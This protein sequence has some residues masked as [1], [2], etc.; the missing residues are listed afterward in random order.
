MRLFTMTAI[1]SCLFA[2]MSLADVKFIERGDTKFSWIDLH[3]SGEI[4][5]DTVNRFKQLFQHFTDSD[6]HNIS[7]RVILTSRGGTVPAAMEIGHFL[8]E[9]EFNAVVPSNQVCLSSC[10]LIFV[11]AVRRNGV[12]TIGLHRPYFQVAPDDTEVSG[13][14][15]MELYDDVRD[16]LDEMNIGQRLFEIMMS[17]PPEDMVTYTGWRNKE[18]LRL[19]PQ[20]DPVYAELQVQERAREIGIST[21][22]LRQRNQWALENCDVEN[23][24]FLSCVYAEEW[25]LSISN[26]LQMRDE[27]EQQ[28]WEVRN[29]FDCMNR[30]MRQQLGRP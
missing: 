22:Q 5:W 12:G 23:D 21:T 2:G 11:G 9:H 15:I 8:R 1:F 18:L 7:G 27:S 20:E 29:R 19:I 30:F 4:T 26:Y 3:V 6:E 17:T 25:G 24:N 14:D 13:V 16:Y 28:C 10:V